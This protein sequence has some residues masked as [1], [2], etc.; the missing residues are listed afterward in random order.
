MCDNLPRVVEFHESLRDA[1]EQLHDP[2]PERAL[3]YNGL[4]RRLTRSGYHHVC[5]VG[6]RSI[7]SRPDDT[8]RDA[9][10][11]LEQA[12]GS[13]VFGEG[14]VS[15]GEDDGMFDMLATGLADPEDFLV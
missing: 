9:A 8:E 7:Y 15:W 12:D 3:T 5:Q 1:V 13:Q 2:S 14:A 6:G 4:H 10:P 11:D